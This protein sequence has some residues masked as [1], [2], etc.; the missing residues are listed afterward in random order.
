M[1]KQIVTAAIASTVMAAAGATAHAQRA[2]DLAT[3][4]RGDSITKIGLDL[5]LG[6]ISGP[7][8]FAYDVALRIEPY[9]QYVLP[10]GFGFYGAFP[11][12]R[13]F[14]GRTA[15]APEDTLAI[16]NL[17][18]GLLYVIEPHRSWSVVFRGGVALPTASDCFSCANDPDRALTNFLA[19]YARLTD[20]ALVEARA[21]HLRLAVSPLF[22]ANRL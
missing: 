10:M 21:T 9:G 5:G 8:D 13:S 6:V 14:G 12:A 2:P 11:I 16:G 4:D 17:D 1:V 15:P 19:A 22:H 3:L 20:I 7:Y 18:L